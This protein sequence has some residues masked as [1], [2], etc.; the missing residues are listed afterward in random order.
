MYV[1]SAYLNND[2]VD[3]EDLSKPLIVASCGTFHLHTKPVFP[4]LRPKGRLDFQLLYIASGKAHFYFND[5]ETIVTAGNMVIY[6][7]GELQRY[8]YYAADQT[9]V[10]WVH[11]TGSE[12]YELLKKSGISEKQN[13]INTGTSIAFSN[14]FLGIIQELQ[15]RNAEYE[16]MCAMYLEQLF[17][18]LHREATKDRSHKSEFLDSE[19]E[20]AK[21]YFFE[22]YNTE[23]SIEDY[24][25]KKGMSVSYFIR[26]F[27]QY[28]NLTPMQYILSVRITNA[29][30]LLE[31]TDYTV[32]EIS[33]IIGYDNPLYFSRL[34][35]KQN[36]I[37]PREYRQERR[38]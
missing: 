26:N 32:A 9:E 25:A 18:L 16:K 3:F 29:Q 31:T 10:F 38:Q 5:K 17:I 28:Y 4:T 36:G 7:P 30:T 14:M 34:F 21:Q 13:L 33:N 1:N 2:Y 27:K 8:L 35:H 23:I 37:S 11:F 6:R 15:H 24:A 19:M 12:A 22:N 20:K